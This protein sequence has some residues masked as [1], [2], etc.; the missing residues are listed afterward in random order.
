M[1]SAP[2]PSGR[3]LSAKSSPDHSV[4]LMNQSIN[5]PLISLAKQVAAGSI[6]VA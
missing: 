2:N 5:S 6:A 3:L 1:S 4:N